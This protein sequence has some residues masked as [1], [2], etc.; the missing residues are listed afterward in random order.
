MSH[1]LRLACRVNFHSSSTASTK[2]PSHGFPG[3]SAPIH[4]PTAGRLCFGVTDPGKV[5]DMCPGIAITGHF[6]P[7]DR[8][9]IEPVRSSPG[10]DRSSVSSARRLTERRDGLDPSLRSRSSKTA[11]GVRSISCARSGPWAV[12]RKTFILLGH[13]VHRQPAPARDEGQWFS[14]F[15]R[16]V[17]SP[18]PRVAA[19]TALIPIA[20]ETAQRVETV[21]AFPQAP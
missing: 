11:F 20:N 18:S 1:T 2:A 13:P 21:N 10:S 4:T 12:R 3:L 16:T 7:D 14:P 8:T 19:G 17:T 6:F 9:R 15:T 5:P